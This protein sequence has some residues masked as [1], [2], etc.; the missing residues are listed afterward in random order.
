[1]IRALVLRHFDGPIKCAMVQKNFPF[2]MEDEGK[3]EA[4]MTISTALSVSKCGWW[5]RKGFDGNSF[6]HGD[7]SPGNKFTLNHSIIHI[8]LKHILF[9]GLEND[10]SGEKFLLGDFDGTLIDKLRGSIPSSSCDA[11]NQYDPQKIV[12]AIMKKHI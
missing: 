4:Y 11:Q 1:M 9:E 2:H 6:K 12:D 8:S 5:L 3:D 10:C 7:P